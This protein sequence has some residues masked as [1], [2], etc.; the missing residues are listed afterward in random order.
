MPQ[1]SVIHE[2]GSVSADPLLFPEPSRDAQ[3]VG[4]KCSLAFCCKP[5]QPFLMTLSVP[6]SAKPIYQSKHE[7]YTPCPTTQAHLYE[8]ELLPT[9]C[10]SNT[11]GSFSPSSFPAGISLFLYAHEMLPTLHFSLRHKHAKRTLRP[12]V[13]KEERFVWTPG[14]IRTCELLFYN[15]SS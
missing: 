12:Y 7:M 4:K 9:P 1:P 14:Q 2:Q 5:K 10:R 11:A 8:Y 3:Q 15:L 6:L 13:Q